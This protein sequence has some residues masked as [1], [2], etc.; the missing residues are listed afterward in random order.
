MESQDMDQS[1]ESQDM[2]QSTESK[3]MNKGLDKIQ[4]AVI[5][6]YK[7]LALGEIPGTALLLAFADKL[8]S[9]LAPE[10]RA[11]LKT[12]VPALLEAALA[13]LV[14]PELGRIVERFDICPVCC[15]TLECD[16][17]DNWDTEE[18]L[19]ERWFCPSCGLFFLRVYRL[20]S[21]QCVC[22]PE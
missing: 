8:D 6:L 5:Q 12:R 14:T 9:R 21:V 1:M 3:D 11:A 13:R 10:E 2:D 4:I 18:E 22:L 20:S 7:Q 16:G 19:A 15:H 17:L